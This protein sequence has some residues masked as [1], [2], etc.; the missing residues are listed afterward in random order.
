MPS[1]RFT[2]RSARKPALE[3]ESKTSES[4]VR[5]TTNRQ[6]EQ[7]RFSWSSQSVWSLR[8]RLCRLGPPFEFS[9]AEESPKPRLFLAC[10]IRPP[11][12][13]IKPRWGVFRLDVRLVRSGEDGLTGSVK[14]L[15]LPVR[16]DK[17]VIPTFVVPS[18]QFRRTERK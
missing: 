11:E 3:A 14:S 6:R 7:I 8:C 9:S 2:P 5:G 13:R 16:L 4:S 12:E 15:R 18:H 17:E 10:R 1:F